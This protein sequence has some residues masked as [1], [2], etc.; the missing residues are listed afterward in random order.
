[1]DKT[2]QK[3]DHYSSHGTGK[4]E[5]KNAVEFEVRENAVLAKLRV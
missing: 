3:H 5:M 2:F 1:M 4:K